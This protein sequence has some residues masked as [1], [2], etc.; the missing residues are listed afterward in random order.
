M[1]DLREPGS[2]EERHCKDKNISN[3]L[4][5][6]ERF[7]KAAAKPPLWITVLPTQYYI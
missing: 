5:E 3:T 1:A 7:A 4:M 2:K 6:R